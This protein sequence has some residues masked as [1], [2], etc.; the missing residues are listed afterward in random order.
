MSA[1]QDAAPTGARRPLRIKPAGSNLGTELREVWAYR[2]L[3]VFLVWRDIKVRHVQS[4]LGPLWAIVVPL[5]QMVV[6]TFIFGRLA[7][8]KG[9]YHVPYPLFVFAGLLPWTYFASSLT[10]S[11][12][13]VLSNTNLITKVYVPRLILPLASIAVPLVD[14]AIA[15]AVLLCMFASYQRAPHWHAVVT[16]VFLGLALLTAFG[17]GLW[18][19]ALNVRYRDIVFVV[20]LLTQL[21]LF[22]SPVIYGATFI[23]PGWQWLIAL[24]PM[25]GVIDGFRWAVLGRGIPH[26]GLFAT[27]LAVGLMLT[28][29]GIAYF[30]HAQRKFADL[31]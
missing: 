11:S 18:L 23:P 30:R 2:E 7:G 10:Q 1:L 31:I 24:N 15:F 13:S 6:F 25:T 4:I 3:L 9:E 5:M 21:W 17:V 27:S 14:F 12:R 29:S 16:P 26:Y 8:I 22:A 19:S 28:V 20:P